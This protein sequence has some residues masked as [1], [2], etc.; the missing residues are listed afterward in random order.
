MSS[1]LQI[2]GSPAIRA[3]YGQSIRYTLTALTS[4][5]RHY[6]DPDLVLVV[7]GGL[8]L[9]GV[10]LPF[11]NALSAVVL[12]LSGIFLVGTVVY[13]RRQERMERAR[14]ARPAGVPGT[15]GA[16]RL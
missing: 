12:I 8:A 4:F 1:Y 13:A 6:D 7:L 10:H 3:A 9:A 11:I 2:D 15:G 5:I 16:Y 14:A